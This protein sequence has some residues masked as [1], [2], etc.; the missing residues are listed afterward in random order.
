MRFAYLNVSKQSSQ[1]WINEIMFQKYRS[2]GEEN[3][4][5]I[6]E[7][8]YDE[9]VKASLNKLDYENSLIT[10][11]INQQRRHFLLHELDVSHLYTTCD[12]EMCYGLEDINRFENKYQIELA[13]W[14]D[15]LTEGLSMSKDKFT[16]KKWPEFM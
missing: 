11:A 2:L 3:D 14:L 1:R 6:S 12:A 10:M 9:A 16:I 7:D 15:K 13:N 8:E 4:I 5:D